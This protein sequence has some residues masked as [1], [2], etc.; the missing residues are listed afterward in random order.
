MGLAY[1]FAIKHKPQK[2]KLWDKEKLSANNGALIIVLEAF[3]QQIV[4]KWKSFSRCA[5]VPCSRNT[6]KFEVDCSF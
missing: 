5:V 4:S 2:A 3:K 6:E 1:K